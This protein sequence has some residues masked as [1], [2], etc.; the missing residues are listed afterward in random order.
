M[1]MIFRSYTTNALPA[2]RRFLAKTRSFRRAFQLLICF[3]H[4]RFDS[5]RN[6]LNSYAKDVSGKKMNTQLITSLMREQLIPTIARQEFHF[7]P[8]TQAAVTSNNDYQS[9]FPYSL[10]SHSFFEWVWCVEEYAFL[11]LKNTV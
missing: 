4:S 2:A 10:H 1:C 3:F 9:V 5:C 7:L 11:N 6:R 8:T